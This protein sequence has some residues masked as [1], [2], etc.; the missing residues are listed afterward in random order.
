MNN[1]RG[2]QDVTWVHEWADRA[3]EVHVALESTDAAAAFVAATIRPSAAWP[4]FVSAATPPTT[5]IVGSKEAGATGQ[6]E[7]AARDE[8]AT[9][10]C[11]HLGCGAVFGAMPKAA[12]HRCCVFPS[13]TSLV[14]AFVAVRNCLLIAVMFVS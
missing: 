1:L 13:Y 8:L 7:A 5:A 2:L 11:G 9:A 4:R 6:H 3:A 10:L 14:L 12:S